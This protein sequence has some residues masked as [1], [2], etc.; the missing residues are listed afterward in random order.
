MGQTPTPVHTWGM[1]FFGFD[2]SQNPGERGHPSSKAPGF[3]ETPDHFAGLPSSATGYDD[4]GYVLMT[5]TDHGYG[6][7]QESCGVGSI[8]RIHMTGSGMPLTRRTMPSMT[9]PSEARVVPVRFPIMPFSAFLLKVHHLQAATS[10]LQV[11][12]PKLPA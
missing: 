9:I 10:T 5:M 3:G 4:E 2:P 1:S 12:L 6:A 8:L 7:E 11:P